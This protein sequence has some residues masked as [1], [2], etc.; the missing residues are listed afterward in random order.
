[1]ARAGCRGE[2][3]GSGFSRRGQT[4]PDFRSTDSLELPVEKGRREKQ[5]GT[6]SDTCDASGPGF[7]QSA[8]KENLFTADLM[9]VEPNNQ[10]NEKAKAC[11]G[12]CR[13]AL[14]PAGRY[15]VTAGLEQHWEGL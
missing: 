5:Q 4:G 15:E 7:V 6:R 14:S 10:L 13:G 11:L 1:M 2:G 12:G 3:G 9:V 8:G